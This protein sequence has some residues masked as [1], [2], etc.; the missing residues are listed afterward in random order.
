MSRM[1]GD[2]TVA[3]ADA[4]AAHA[5]GDVDW[6]RPLR[7]VRPELGRSASMVA[8]RDTWRRWWLAYFVYALLVSLVAQVLLALR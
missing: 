5:A 8:L 6:S 2:V 4:R 7:E 3:L 1:V